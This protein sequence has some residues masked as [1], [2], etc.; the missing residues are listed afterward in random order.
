MDSQRKKVVWAL[1]HYNEL[2]AQAVK[3]I[4]DLAAV[5]LT[6][7]L[8]SIG[9]SSGNSVEQRVLR[10]EDS[11]LNAWRWC[12]VVEKTYDH[13]RPDGKC[14]LIDL[15]FFQHLP[16][17]KVARQLHIAERTLCYWQDSII[18]TAIYWAQEYNLI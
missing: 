11:R 12:K 7:Q 4:N 3:V 10:S 15:K 13:Y 17:W 1:K 2:K 18:L 5:G 8:D 14:R 16:K 6:A 9:G